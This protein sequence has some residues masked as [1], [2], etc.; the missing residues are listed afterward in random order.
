MIISTSTSTSSKLLFLSSSSSSYYYYKSSK[1][2]SASASAAIAAR[3]S[4]AV[5]LKIKRSSSSMANASSSSSSGASS[6]S[7]ASGAASDGSIYNNDGSNS[8]VSAFK[9]SSSASSFN[10][11]KLLISISDD[12]KNYN[13]GSALNASQ[14]SSDL[15]ESVS[16]KNINSNSPRSKKLPLMV[17][18]SEEDDEND[19]DGGG[20]ASLAREKRQK[21]VKLRKLK[22][23]ALDEDL[24][25]M[26]VN[27]EADYR[28]DGEEFD[29][30]LEKLVKNYVKDVLGKNK[31]A[32]VKEKE[33][34]HFFRFCHRLDFA[35]SGLLAVALKPET[36]VATGFAFENRFTKK[37]YHA[38]LYGHLPLPFKDIQ[39][40][41]MKEDGLL[42]MKSVWLDVS[43][44]DCPILQGHLDSKL[45]MD[46]ENFETKGFSVAALQVDSC[47]A[48]IP[49]DFRMT[50]GDIFCDP[51]EKE[52]GKSKNKSDEKKTTEE[53]KKCN[54]RP[55]RTFIIP[56]KQGYQN[57][58]NGVLAEATECLL[59]PFTGRR[60]QLRIHTLYCGYPIVGDATYL[61]VYQQMLADEAKQRRVVES[62]NAMPRM[63]LH[64]HFLQIK[65]REMFQDKSTK[66]LRKAMKG[67]TFSFEKNF[68]AHAG[69]DFEPGFVP[70]PQ[71]V[72]TISLR[73]DT[74]ASN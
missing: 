70:E 1:A 29:V 58:G 19:E 68:V 38:Y 14:A 44:A 46:T 56:L 8:N 66:K 42:K 39:D 51:D 48:E 61:P 15:S 34:E 52:K 35:T 25:L 6:A 3:A 11:S 36:R 40:F 41:V 20:V 5:S 73:F 47:I 13:S 28:L 57:I 54:G 26:A 2:I 10:T 37:I 43:R 32:E 18:R 59:I 22:V 31:G 17:P 21:E 23:V 27:K 60:H 49:G 16:I 55:S 30:T 71:P 4:F 74:T 12:N 50:L 7:N 72:S 24:G 64:A 65:L 63:F 9:A 53:T 33:K 67:T 69:S 45:K 62:L